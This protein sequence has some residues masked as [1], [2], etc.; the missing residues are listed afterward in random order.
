MSRG[1]KKPTAAWKIHFA[2]RLHNCDKDAASIYCF[3]RPS[4]R[5]WVK[6]TFSILSLYKPVFKKSNINVTLLKSN[7]A[8]WL[9]ID[10][11]NL[12]ALLLF[13]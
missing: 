6:I 5:A 7:F 1:R 2:S 12:L 9:L 10:G 3:I 11:G 4:E 8:K 13:S